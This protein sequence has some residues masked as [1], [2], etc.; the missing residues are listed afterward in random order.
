[1]IFAYL[2]IPKFPDELIEGCMENID[3][4]DKDPMLYET[5]NKGRG[6]ANLATWVSEDADR[7]INHN[8]QERYFDPEY[9]QTPLF[10]ISFYSKNPRNKWWRDGFHGPHTD[11]GRTWALN[12]YI[13]LG[14]PERCPK[15]L[16]LDDR[17][18]RR[19]VGGE[20]AIEMHKWCLLKV[21]VLHAVEKI[22]LGHLRTF[23]SLG[24]NCS[25]DY[26]QDRLKDVIIKDSVIPFNPAELYRE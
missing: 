12:Y 8:I 4:V 17:D 21:N 2:D 11:V 23:V 10:N 1:M 26:I 3:L 25:D 13:N 9:Y 24:L 6:G 7:W 14:D 16:W 20:V 15:T 19:Y 18:G 22:K 5:V